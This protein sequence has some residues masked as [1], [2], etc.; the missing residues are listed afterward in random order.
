MQWSK[1]II[2]FCNWLNDAYIVT[3]F[4]H[5]SFSGLYWKCTEQRPQGRVSLKQTPLSTFILSH[6]NTV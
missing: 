5:V 1:I 4:R 6:N 3:Y 2:I